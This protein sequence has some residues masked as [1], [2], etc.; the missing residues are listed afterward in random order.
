MISAALRGVRRF[1]DRR[2]HNAAPVILMYHRVADIPID[3][4]GL[5]VAP[6]RF[7][8]QIN[9]LTQVRRVV[10][11]HDLVEAERSRSS[12]DKP[13]AA[14][15]FD[16]GYHDV[17]SNARKVLQR[18][19][20]PMTLFVTTG[21]IGTDREFW[22][23]ATSRIFL[24]TEMLPANLAMEIAGTTIHWAVPPV[25]QQ[26]G[27]KKI[28]QEVW[29]R[30]RVLEY[31]SQLKN[32]EQLGRWAGCDLTAREAHR[33]MTRE[34]VRSI[35]DGLITVGA[36]TVNHPTLPAHSIEAQ[37]REIAESRQACEELIDGPV[38]AF[39]YPFGD[40]TDAT[41]SAVRDAGFSMACTVEAGVV[42]PHAD[43]MKLPRL[44]V[45]DWSGDGLLKR[46][47]D[48]LS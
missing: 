7:E 44:Y 25:A 8:E 46:I 42:R 43:P 2:L 32:L 47:K 33:V 40:Y 24:E 13:L 23:D 17:Y 41:V 15:T 26:E 6:A 39:A 30:L 10:H 1:I 20:C 3:P 28:F 29:A 34:E 35:S 37:F 9:A 36:H 5:A 4:W 27:R 16:D 14:V 18:H 22:W 48:P 12:R 21:T 31:E 45:G 38:S 19:D 11:L